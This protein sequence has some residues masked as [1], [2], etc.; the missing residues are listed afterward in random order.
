MVPVK[1][2]LAWLK[3]CCRSPWSA[4]ITSIIVFTSD[5]DKGAQGRHL[6]RP[7]SG[8]SRKRRRMKKPMKQKAATKSSISATQASAMGRAS[9]Q[10]LQTRY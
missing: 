5:T 4:T 3:S 8:S 6:F 10:V 2:A 1:R 7:V 9:R